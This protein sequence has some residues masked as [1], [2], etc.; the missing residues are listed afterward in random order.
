VVALFNVA[1]RWD[2]LLHVA[3]P[4]VDHLKEFTQSALAARTE[5]RRIETS[6]VFDYRRKSVRPVWHGA[7]EQGGS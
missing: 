5:V 4:S 2:F 1:G 6:L 3:V 7:G